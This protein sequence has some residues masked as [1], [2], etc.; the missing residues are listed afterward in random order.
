MKKKLIALMLCL[1]SI[2]M[3]SCGSNGNNQSTSSQDVNVRVSESTAKWEHIVNI[4]HYEPFGGAALP[5]AYLG[6]YG[7]VYAKQ[8]GGEVHYKID[9][10]EGP[11]VP[12][13]KNPDYGSSDRWKYGKYRYCF[14]YEGKTYYINF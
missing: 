7:G 6:G 9:L 12:I 10:F 8:I 5:C 2:T 11:E 1:V 4:E 14:D 3:V 13:Y